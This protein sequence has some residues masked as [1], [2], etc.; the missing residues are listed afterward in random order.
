M[1]KPSRYFLGVWTMSLAGMVGLVV[2]FN[3]LVDPYLMFGRPRIQGFNARKPGIETQQYMMKIY[4]VLRTKP[5]TVILGNSRVMHIDVEHPAWPEQD[6]P[7]YNLGLGAA[8]PYVSYRYLQ[9]V[10]SQRHL[11]LVVLGLDFEYFLTV[12]EAIHP[13][14]PEFE[15]RFKVNQ[16]RTSN[17]QWKL[18]YI[19]DL[20]QT[21]LSVHTLLDSL[22]TLSGN[23]TGRSS[24]Y[25]SGRN[26][27]YPHIRFTEL[28][29]SYP[30]VALTD[31]G[32]IKAWSGRQRNPYAMKD[33]RALLDL[34]RS[35]GTRVILF[36]D[37][38]HADELE[39]LDL[40]GYWEEFET[41]KREL[42][43]LVREYS[44]PDDTRRIL[45]WDFADYN[46]YA[47][48]PVL[49]NGSALR[50]YWEPRHYNTALGDVI[51]CRIFGSGNTNFG[52]LLNP[53]TIDSHLS[54]V[55]R[56]QRLYRDR[57]PADIGRVR[58]LHKA[59]VN[60]SHPEI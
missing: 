34:C 51:L 4:D 37:P 10:L 23:L 9:H 56:R 12:D 54:V 28:A 16:D 40:L 49:P 15:S 7:V 58:E 21:T 47:T 25:I 1:D 52:A 43:N 60:A 39:I 44:T 27:W 59:V 11:A 2:L 20:V 13:I 32:T 41:W 33:L 42:A 14:E 5:N 53:E 8:G 22:A 3:V 6:R 50:W 29:G 45:L 35:N 55:R 18:Q 26:V 17:K 31:A 48:E 30:L 57:Q 24:D 36:I 38:V 46:E 19:R